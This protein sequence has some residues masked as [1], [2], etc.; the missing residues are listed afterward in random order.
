MASLGMGHQNKVLPSGSMKQVPFPH[1]RH[2]SVLK[3]CNACHDLFPKEAGS[4][5]R[6]IGEGTLMKKKVMNTCISCHRSMKQSGLMTGPLSCKKCHT[7][8]NTNN[9]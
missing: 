9:Q 5:Q 7:I 1:S 6:L 2:Q 3:S 4:I 8:K